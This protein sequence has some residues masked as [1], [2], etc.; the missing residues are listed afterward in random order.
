VEVFRCEFHYADL[1]ERAV[2]RKSRIESFE[3]DKYVH[4]IVLAVCLQSVCNVTSIGS[5]V[6]EEFDDHSL[7]ILHPKRTFNEFEGRH[8]ENHF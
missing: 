7:L 6:P 2:P 5:L 4:Q 3:I 1:D 8:L